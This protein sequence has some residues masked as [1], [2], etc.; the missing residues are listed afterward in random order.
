MK[1]VRKAFDKI[2]HTKIQ[3]IIY[4]IL[5]LFSF[6]PKI[7]LGENCPNKVCPSGTSKCELLGGQTCA[8]RVVDVVSDNDI[9]KILCSTHRIEK[10]EDGF[11]R[12]RT[13]KRGHLDRNLMRSKALYFDAPSNYSAINFPLDKI[14][15][16]DS[17][18]EQKRICKE[19][20]N[21]FDEDFESIE[22]KNMMFEL[23][24][25]PL[26]KGRK[27][28]PTQNPGFTGKTIR[29]HEVLKQEKDRLKAL[30][31][32]KVATEPEGTITETEGTVIE[33]D[34]E[35]PKTGETVTGTGETVVVPKPAK[36]TTKSDTEDNSLDTCYKLNQKRP[37]YLGNYNFDKYNL[38]KKQL[39]FSLSSNP[40]WKESLVQPGKY[41]MVIPESTATDTTDRI[42]LSYLRFNNISFD[43]ETFNFDKA[44]NCSSVFTPPL[45]YTP[46]ENKVNAPPEDEVNPHPEDENKE[47]T[48]TQFGSIASTPETKDSVTAPLSDTNKTKLCEALDTQIPKLMKDLNK[49]DAKISKANCRIFKKQIEEIQSNDFVSNNPLKSLM[50]DLDCTDTSKIKYQELRELYNKLV[51][52][53][54]LLSEINTYKDILGTPSTTEQLVD[55]SLYR[56]SMMSKTFKELGSKITGDS[57][58]IQSSLNSK[59][60]SPSGPIPDI[61]KCKQLFDEDFYKKLNAVMEIAISCDNASDNKT[62]KEDNQKTFE[63]LDVR[64]TEI[65]KAYTIEINEPETSEPP[66]LIGNLTSG[67]S[68]SYSDEMLTSMCEKINN[69]VIMRNS[70]KDLADFRDELYSPEKRE[71]DIRAQFAE[72]YGC[73]FDSTEGPTGKKCQ[74]LLEG[75]DLSK[76]QEAYEKAIKAVSR[77]INGDAP[78][79]EIQELREFLSASVAAHQNICEREGDGNNQRL[80]GAGELFLP[81]CNIDDDSQ[82]SDLKIFISN[83]QGIVHKLDEFTSFNLSENSQRAS[84][85]KLLAMCRPGDREK[86]KQYQKHYK[87]FCGAMDRV[88]SNIYADSEDAKRHEHFMSEYDNQCGGLTGCTLDSYYDEDKG[89]IAYEARVH[90]GVAAAGSTAGYVAKGALEGVFG[91]GQQYYFTQYGQMNPM[92]SLM[93]SYS[94]G[95]YGIPALQNYSIDYLV[96]TLTYRNAYYSQL[97]N[98]QIETLYGKPFIFNYKLLYP[99][100][101]FQEIDTFY[102]GF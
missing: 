100:Q 19:H 15:S 42:S 65:L 72:I 25:Y 26:K 80:N 76:S 43:L 82:N 11:K 14:S 37:N 86:Y 33:T 79:K 44:P 18:D 8:C 21:K 87:K 61:N 36:H 78:G 41:Y 34:E 1:V 48:S 47:E 64:V 7:S 77:L 67:Q 83:A 13:N 69:D 50:G 71:A 5:L 23:Q 68:S 39:N 102:L 57:K 12:A 85:D 2:H 94:F 89:K 98:A 16:G 22:E 97:E 96:P 60:C 73:V 3:I 58:D 45:G 70:G 66:M 32:A 90:P 30:A 49:A 54:A 62:C 101:S 52:R 20:F 4:L 95:Q 46:P 17:L 38:G 84:F 92:Q 6:A 63:A 31:A 81:K 55:R 88:E 24:C 75:S 59:I 35:V 40:V 74:G 29:C 91:I 9:N 56:L 10:G 28:C 27:I 99:N 53:S 93:N 51:A